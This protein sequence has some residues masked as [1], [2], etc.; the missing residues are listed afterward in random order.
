MDAVEISAWCR[1]HQLDPTHAIV[2][3]GVNDVTDDVLLE[4]LSSVKAF[5]RTKIVEKRPDLTSKTDFV[6]VRTSVDV[7]TQTLPDQVGVPGQVGPW[8]IHLLPAAPEESED[9]Q[10]KLLTFLQHEGKS[11][12]DVKGLLNPPPLDVN[13]ALINAI[14]SLMDKCNSAPAETQNYRKL[15]MFS[16]VRPTPS[17]EEEYDAWA[18]Q[19]TH[20]LEEWQC[21]DGIKK[22]RVVESLKG[23][24]ADIIRFL[25]AQNPNATVHDYMH[26]L[27]TAFGTTENSS[28]LL[29][30]FRHTFQSEGEKLSSYLLRLDKLLHSI[31]RK[32]GLQL[33]D[34]NR[35]RIEQIVRGA[36]QHNMI[37]MRIRMTH[38]LRPPP[39][40]NE[41]L[42]EVREEEDMLQGKGDAKCTVMSKPV[43]SVTKPVPEVK[44]DPEVERLKNELSAMKFEMNNLKVA[45][46]A[47]AAAQTEM[48]S[49]RPDHAIKNKFKRSAPPPRQKIYTEQPGIFCYRCGEDGHYMRECDGVE[50]LQRVN[51]RLI[52]LTKNL[53]NYHGAQ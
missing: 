34:M 12:D 15:R 36:L 1:T 2:L 44:A 38:K 42:K 51:R 33:A 50:N 25:K 47:A 16:G 19:T 37:A 22:Q 39:T 45:T 29:V 7:T 3:S 8:P 41:L 6:L 10:A 26:S 5:G 53:G 30:K 14:S 43:A 18:E 23:P 4:V 46:V 28:D 20:M 31:F 52:K 21:G 9:F 35:L 48:Q 13:V 24:A 27:E 11:I 40:F 32:G 17:G 49:Q